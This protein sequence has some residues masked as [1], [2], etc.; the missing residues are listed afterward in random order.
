NHTNGSRCRGA[1]ASLAAVAGGATAGRGSGVAAGPWGCSTRPGSGGD[2]RGGSGSATVCVI[3]TGPEGLVRGGGNAGGGS[4]V[5]W[6]WPQRSASGFQVW[7]DGCQDDRKG[8]HS[9]CS[10]GARSAGALPL[11]GKT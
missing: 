6:V 2:G 8:T 5:P 10:S 11:G 4:G 1:F 7:A 9:P 3:T